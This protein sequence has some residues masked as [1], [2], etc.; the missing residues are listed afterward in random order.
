VF[1]ILYTYKSDR[2]QATIGVERDLPR[3]Y[4]IPVSIV[5][6]HP[7][8]FLGGLLMANIEID[9]SY[10]HILIGHIFDIKIHLEE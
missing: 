6:Y 3:T 8:I 10:V 9:L 5:R 7:I 4:V 2:S 1:F